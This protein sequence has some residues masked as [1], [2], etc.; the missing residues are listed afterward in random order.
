MEDYPNIFQEQEKDIFVFNNCPAL[1]KYQIE[2]VENDF[3]LSEIP[4]S[5]G[6][7]SEIEGVDYDDDNNSNIVFLSKQL[8]QDISFVKYNLP[9]FVNVV[10]DSK[11]GFE[12]YFTEIMDE[13]LFKFVDERCE[14]C[15]LCFCQNLSIKL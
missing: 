7:F 5:L 9:A 4:I 14:L 13:D 8:F 3:L 6:T 15:Q 10:Q 1:N 2:N 11:T 12:E